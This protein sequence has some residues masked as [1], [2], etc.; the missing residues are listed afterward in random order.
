MTEISCDDG[1]NRVHGWQ[2]Q[3]PWWS[4]C[5][6]TFSKII[7]N[8]Q[9][10]GSI[11]G[12]IQRYLCFHIISFPKKL[13]FCPCRRKR[14][15]LYNQTGKEEVMRLSVRPSALPPS[16]MNGLLCSNQFSDTCR[17][18]S[19]SKRDPQDMFS[20]TEGNCTSWFSGQK[21]KWLFSK[22]NDINSSTSNCIYIFWMKILILFDEPFLTL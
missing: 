22:L 20:H 5:W 14:R 18:C 10:C 9:I 1:Q 12:C 16:V 7:F 21:C 6:F 3:H 13:E 4:S 15:A 2:T 8:S 11:G 17:Q 19:S